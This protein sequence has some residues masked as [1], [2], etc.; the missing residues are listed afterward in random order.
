MK[1]TT[2]TQEQTGRVGLRRQ[3]AI[4]REMVKTLK[5]QAGD[6]VAFSEQ[7]NGVLTRP[8]RIA[9]GDDTLTPAEARLVRR[10]ED[11]LKRGRSKS[12]RAIKH[13]LSH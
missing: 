8:T 11:Q 9:D 13:A 1:K 2:A 12:W 6:L 10:G 7:K 5:L 3:V 4:P